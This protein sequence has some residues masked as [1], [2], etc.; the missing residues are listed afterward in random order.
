MTNHRDRKRVRKPR[1][2]ITNQNLKRL[3]EIRKTMSV[4]ELS[5]RSELP[6]ML[7]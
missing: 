2:E 5:K 1:I 3:F 6:Y 4:P 7:V